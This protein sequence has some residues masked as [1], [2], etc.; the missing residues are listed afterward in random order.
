MRN[1]S[2]FPPLSPPPLPARAPSPTQVAERNEHAAKLDAIRERLKQLERSGGDGAAKLEANRAAA[3]DL[4]ERADAQTRG[5]L[6][7]AT[8]ESESVLASAATTTLV[9][10]GALFALA[11]V[12]LE[13]AIASYPAAKVE[14]TRRRI[15]EL[16]R[17][18]G[19]G[20]SIDEIT[21]I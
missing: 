5:V 2:D 4:F 15:R 16:V 9:A 20:I 13:E 12:T 8:A 19:P 17:Q 11:A 10:Q 1:D 6:S 7:A 3:R 21:M 18:G 14:A